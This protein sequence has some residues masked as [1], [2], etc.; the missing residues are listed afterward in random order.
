[1][2]QEK[3]NQSKYNICWI[4]ILVIFVGTIIYPIVFESARQSLSR[5]EPTQNSLPLTVVVYKQ[6]SDTS[7]SVVT[8]V[9]TLPNVIIDTP[10]VSPLFERDLRL[11]D[12]G[13][14]VKML[15][16]FLNKRGFIVAKSGNGSLGHENDI[17][18]PG[19]QRA[20]KEFQEAYSDVL[21]KP[22]GL[23]KGTGF[24]GEKTREF[25]NS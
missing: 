8:P 2:K 4:S 11:G 21:L 10:K 1:M 25:I 19:T 22:F 5:P 15:Q 3:T 12:R 9:D 18:G 23:T 16:E 24:F 14:D 6:N 7:N 13:E 20:L 17:F